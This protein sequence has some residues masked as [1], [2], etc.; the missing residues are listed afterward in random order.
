MDIPHQDISSFDI[1]I[2]D[3]DRDEYF[4]ERVPLQNGY[5]VSI[6]FGS[7]GLTADVT[8]KS[9]SSLTAVRGAL[10]NTD[11]GDGT[12]VPPEPE[13]TPE[14]AP[15]PEPVSRSFAFTVYNESSYDIFSIHMG[16]LTGSSENDVDMLP[17]ILRAGDDIRISGEVA[18]GSS[19]ITE[20]TLF[21]TDTDG[22]KNASHATFNPWT[23]LY[24]NVTWDSSAGGY[25]CEFVY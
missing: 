15:V 9:G 5:R 20:W 1:K 14:P 18:A 24:V 6:S 3:E 17:Q 25:V 7:G 2:V 19:E 22:D 8:D 11:A 4:F 23:L 12:T 10:G 13:P 16:P 21:I